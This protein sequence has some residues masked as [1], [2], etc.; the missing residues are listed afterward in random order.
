MHYTWYHK[1]G[2]GVLVA[3]WLA[4][5]SHMIG[6]FLVVAEPLEKPA[7]AVAGD[8]QPTAAP[9]AA[10]Q[11]AAAMGDA[12]SLLASA[13]AGKGLSVFKKCKACHTSEQGGANRVGPNLWDVV[14]RAKGAAAG[15]NYSDALKSK[16]GVWTLADLDGFLAAPRAFVPGTKMGFAGLKKPGD[17][18]AVIVFLNSL[19]AQ[20]KPLQ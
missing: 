12:I 14:G 18:A 8:A 13:D 4:F 1:L 17:R 2:F 3:L 11:P 19:S 10:K 16:G 6:E 7:F 5:G 15:F 20:P 9:E